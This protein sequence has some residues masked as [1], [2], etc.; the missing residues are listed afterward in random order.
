MG[1]GPHNIFNPGQKDKIVEIARLV[2]K[3]KFEGGAK[4]QESFGLALG[5]LTQPGVSALLAG[6]MSLNLRRAEMLAA[7]A[8]Y[9]SLAA[10]IGEYSWIESNTFP[11]LAV[12]LEFWE[13]GA[14]RWPNYVIELARQGFWPDDVSPQ[15]WTQR[16]DRLTTWLA[17][18]PRQK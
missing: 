13:E 3:E 2:F 15:E 11:K 9:R 17:E 7:L 4:P 12:C 18:F 8:G 10:M 14:S 5:G 16:L 1:S 6:H